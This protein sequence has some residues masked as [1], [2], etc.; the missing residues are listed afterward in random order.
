MQ[1]TNKIFTVVFVYCCQSVPFTVTG[2]A[3]PNQE[4]D[5]L[6]S[7]KEYTRPHA[8]CYSNAAI[9]KWVMTLIVLVLLINV[10]LGFKAPGDLH[11]LMWSV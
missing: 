2:K 11:S 9:M 6:T 1:T 3:H 7:G 4:F 8:L 5:L 10:F